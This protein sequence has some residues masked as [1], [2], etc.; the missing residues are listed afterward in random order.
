MPLAACSHPDCPPAGVRVEYQDRVVETQRP[1]KVEAPAKPAPVGS[2]PADYKAIA[3]ILKAKLVEYEGDGKWA[4]KMIAA[5]DSCTQ[6]D[7]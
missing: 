5:L 1:C 3:F 2:L 7:E 4:D 6:E